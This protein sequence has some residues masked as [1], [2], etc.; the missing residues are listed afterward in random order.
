MRV[1]YIAVSSEGGG[2]GRS[3]LEMI[4]TIKKRYMPPFTD[5]GSHTLA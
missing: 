1:L 3:M 5:F 4:S 2:A